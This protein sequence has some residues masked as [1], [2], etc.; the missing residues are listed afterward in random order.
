MSGTGKGNFP[1]TFVLSVQDQGVAQK[2]NQVKSGLE[3][4]NQA[5]QPLNKNLKKTEE[6]MKDA[7]KEVEK[8]SKSIVTLGDESNTTAK[9]SQGLAEKF[10]RNKGLIFGMTMLSSGVI[11]AVGMFSMYQGAADK[12]KT[13]QDELNKVVE[14]GVTGTES[15]QK[16]LEKR[17]AAQQRVNDL[18]EAGKTNTP[19][20]TEAVRT[21]KE[22]NDD[23]NKI[24]EGGIKGTKEYQDASSDLADAQRGLQ[25]VQRNMILSMTDLIPMSLLAVS[26]FLNLAEQL[27]KTKPALEALGTPMTDLRTATNGMTTA[28]KALRVAMIAIPLVAIATALLAV[29]TNAGGF[30]D[31]L[32]ELG[33][34]IGTL[35]PAIKPLLQWIKDFAE[36]LGLT[37]K[38]MD[39]SKA[40]D[41][42]VSGFQGAL[43]KIQTTDWK[44]VITTIVEGIGDYLKN[45]NWDDAWSSFVTAFGETIKFLGPILDKIGALILK[46]IETESPKWWKGFQLALTASLTWVS[47]GIRTIGAQIANTIVTESAKWWVGFQNQLGKDVSWVGTQLTKIGKAITSWTTWEQVGKDI[48]ANISKGLGDAVSSIGA[49][50][51]GLLKS[52]QDALF[53]SG[54]LQSVF[55]SEGEGGGM[56]FTPFLDLNLYNQKIAELKTTTQQATFAVSQMFTSMTTTIQ[57]TLTTM[58]ASFVNAFI[59]LQT[60]AT[61]QIGATIT[62]FTNFRNSVQ[63]VLG[64]ITTLFAPA[65]AN[66]APIVS[67]ATSQA[68]AA[69]VTMNTAIKGVFAQLDGVFKAFATSVTTNSAAAGN[70]FLNSFVKPASEGLKIF[71]TAY[72][73]TA[74]G[75]QAFAT[76][77]TKSSTTASG[78]VLA[79][80]TSMTNNLNALK[81]VYS[82]FASSVVSSLNKVA[83]AAKSAT[84]A[85]NSMAAAARK[86]AA[87]KSAAGLMHGGSFVR[88]QHGFSGVINSP[89]SYGGVQMGEGFKPELV[90][91]QP[92]TRG[93]GNTGGLN[94]AMAG[95]GISGG[96]SGGPIVNNITVVLDGR[97]IQRFVEK[98]ALGNYS[99]MV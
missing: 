65:F 89:T 82:S 71:V 38:A 84:N 10:Q 32:N 58:A 54:G 18:V 19:A 26:G 75:Y 69:F 91:V 85:L 48:W 77:I 1:L 64:T 35:I 33:E 68:T 67:Q 92:L 57:T 11:E 52:I 29:K 5:V 47:N 22:T 86:A 15:Y 44:A 62:L 88:G 14:G 72:T 16:A 81:S 66:L 78:S 2:F 80:K 41:L 25:F 70:G 49:A 12:V 6:N 83:S 51:G 60:N 98:T 40:W 3:G 74:K 24:T 99:N 55:A 96:G 21:L 73:A 9:K 34:K 61:T 93:S 4:T 56:F 90:T 37:E 59:P 8:G 7:G 17:N 50:G 13:A 27:K 46:T 79:M 36:A 63:Q 23:L 45:W 39:L 43:E 42:L 76:S 97:V 30:R 53:G 20:Y 94:R 87:A 28:S 95:N 31:M